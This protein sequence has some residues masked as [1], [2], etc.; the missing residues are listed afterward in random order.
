M[1]KEQIISQIQGE[2]TG[3]P[4]RPAVNRTRS[5]N[6]LSCFRNSPNPGRS[7]TIT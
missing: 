1:V 3:Q 6:S 7:N 4:S 5:A 2:V